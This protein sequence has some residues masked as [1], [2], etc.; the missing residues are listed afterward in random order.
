MSPLRRLN[1]PLAAL[2][3]VA[4]GVLAVLASRVRDWV[5]MTDEMQY[6]K[7]AT[8]IGDGSLLPTLRGDHVSTYSQLYPLLLSPLYALLDAPDA[9]Q[10]AHVLNGVLYASAVVPAYLL[11]RKVGLTQLW[12]LGVAALTVLAPWNT[13]AGFVMTESAA[14]PVF[15]WTVLAFQHALEAQSGRRDALALAAIVFALF[16]RTQF[17]V[18]AFV[19]PLAVVLVDGRSAVRRHRV[20]AAAYALGAVAALVIAVTGGLA[21]LLGRYEVTATEGSIL[22]FDALVHAGAH[23]DL[24]AL[25]TGIVTLLLGGAWL[26]SRRTAFSVLALVTVVALTLESASYDAR[27]AGGLTDVRD[28]YLFYVAPLLLLATALALRDG[29]PRVALG[30]VTL[31]FAVTI[32]AY[33]FFEVKG[34]YVDSPVAVATGWIEDSGSAWFVAMFAI[35]MALAIVIVRVSSRTLA[36]SVAALMA[37]W[38]VSMSAVGWTRILESNGP[39]GRPVDKGPAFVSNWVDSVVPDG[40]DVALLP[41]PT[42]SDWG[43]SAVLWWDTEFWNRSVD[44]AFVIGEGWD[45]APFPHDRLAVDQATGEIRGT[46]DA[47]QYVVSA[48]AESRLRLAGADLATNFNLHVLDVLRPYRAEWITSGLDPDGYT[49]DGRAAAVRIFP[50]AGAGPQRV[51]LDVQFAAPQRRVEFRFNGAERALRAREV[52]TEQL[53]VCVAPPTWAEIPIEVDRSVRVPPPPFGP[54]YDL[55]DRNVGPRIA[56]VAVFRSGEPC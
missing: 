11:G 51:T 53:A 40:A 13:I 47:P 30:A 3:T 8:A 4:A 18:L 23:I 7:L 31:F 17:V 35:V 48:A 39:S 43:A 15:L 41:Y 54:G 6:A 46:D 49:R 34:F 16:A 56:A 33:D 20:L 37:A 52:R 55:P 42:T 9:F 28:R 5:V 19:L 21:R 36:L 24:I 32:F 22:P 50:D 29:I 26:V 12:A 38:C 45:Y 14:F 2:V 10:A 1:V 44:H 27:F 25:G